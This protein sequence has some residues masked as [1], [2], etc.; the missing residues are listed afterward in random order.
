MSE[1]FGTFAVIRS[2]GKEYKVSKTNVV[3]LEKLHGEPGSTVQFEEV[4]L[5]G[6]GEKP[7]IIGTPFVK[8]ASVTAEI[9][10]QCRDSKVIVFKKQRRQHYRR[11]N[12]HRQSVTY[13]RIKDIKR[14]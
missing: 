12:G 9:I 2:G 10:E 8:G 7:V 14:A 3:K 13:V 6:S 4:L 5:I 11:K 1:D